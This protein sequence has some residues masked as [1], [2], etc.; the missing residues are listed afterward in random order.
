MAIHFSRLKIYRKQ[1]GLTQED[2]AGRLGVSRQAVAKWERGETLPDIE[3]CIKL[4]DIYGTTVDMLVRDMEKEKHS[5]DGKHVFGIST[6]NEKGQITLPVECR[7]IFNIKSGDAIII[8]GDEERG[9]ALI[10]AGNIRENGG[11][12][13]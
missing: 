12:D 10:N 11:G 6:V 1:H 3:S 9:I 13:F 8:L 2:I 4:A 5:G 7:K